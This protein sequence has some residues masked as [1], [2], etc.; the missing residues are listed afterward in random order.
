MKKFICLLAAIAVIACMTTAVFADTGSFVPSITYKDGPDIESAV[1][2][3][4]DVSA[5]LIVTSITGARE[6]STDI[7]Q[8][9]RDLLLQ[10]YEDLSSGDMKLPIE[11]DYVI[12][13][14]VDVSF[15]L[16]TCEQAGHG[17]MQWL[18]QENTSVT[19][20]FD[21]GVDA[22]ATVTVMTYRDGVWEPIESVTNLGDGTVV[23]VFEHLCPVA[24]CVETEKT[25]GGDTPSPTGDGIGLWVA[26]MAVSA[27]A[28]VTLR[29]RWAA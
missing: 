19:V 11:N 25:S 3:G 5:C 12:R 15:R 13:E 9:A 28:V 6:Q 4:E 29:R 18:D 10:V 7:T 23:C 1:L 17:H 24:F 16:T 20:R 21:L 14:L 26:L 8:A 22:D 2:E 27:A